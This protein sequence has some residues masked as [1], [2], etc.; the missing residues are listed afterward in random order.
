MQTVDHESL[1]LL[2][3]SFKSAQEAGDQCE[4]KDEAREGMR[5]SLGFL[6]R[7]SDTW[8]RVDLRHVRYS[9]DPFVRRWI[10]DHMGPSIR[11][12]FFKNSKRD[13]A[14]EAL[15]FV[16]EKPDIEFAR[17]PKEGLLVNRKGLPEDFNW[18]RIEA[19]EVRV[20]DLVSIPCLQVGLPIHHGLVAEGATIVRAVVKSVTRLASAG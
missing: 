11:D 14:M 20:G 16:C 15:Y 19:S 10:R 12:K 3:E 1:S 4:R 13:T 8:N 2:L 6:N 9:D 17:H 18:I 5:G 7:T